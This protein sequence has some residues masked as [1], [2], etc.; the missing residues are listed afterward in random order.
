MFKFFFTITLF[1]ISA[2]LHVDDDQNGSQDKSDTYRPPVRD[3]YVSP[4]A[5]PDT[6]P[7]SCTPWC[8]DKPEC[9]DDGCGG[10]CGT[11][12]EWSGEVCD[13]GLCVDLADARLS[14]QCIQAVEYVFWG[15][16]HPGDFIISYHASA[17]EYVT[18]TF[19]TTAI[20]LEPEGIEG[21]ECFQGGVY[22]GEAFY[23]PKGGFGCA[24]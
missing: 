18:A 7:S 19:R 14:A 17:G 5:T 16:D 15:N 8:Y 1:L 9:G 20:T 23:L 4:D 13:D 21:C 2:C 22:K 12:D 11:C 24:K 10:S 6:H 3:T